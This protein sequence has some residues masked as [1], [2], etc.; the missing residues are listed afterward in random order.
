[1][2]KTILKNKCSGR[3]ELFVQGCTEAQP[4]LLL[5]GDRKQSV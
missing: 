4:Y 3:G 1:M 2:N 5:V